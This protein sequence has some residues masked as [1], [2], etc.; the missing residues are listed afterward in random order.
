MIDFN[1]IFYPLCAAAV[2]MNIFGAAY[3]RTK[4]PFGTYSLAVGFGLGIS[5][6]GCFVFLVAFASVLT[7]NG[8]YVP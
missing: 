5:I 2:L 4:W 6:A 1:I 7:N 8:W 3:A